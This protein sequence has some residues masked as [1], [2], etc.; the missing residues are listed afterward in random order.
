MELDAV[1]EKSQNRCVAFICWKKTCHG[2]SF[3]HLHWESKS[4]NCKNKADPKDMD[5]NARKQVAQET[6]NGL[7]VTFSGFSKCAIGRG[8]RNTKKNILSP[9]RLRMH[10]KIGNRNLWHYRTTSIN[11]QRI[12]QKIFPK[13][14]NDVPTCLPKVKRLSYH[15]SWMIYF[16]ICPLKW[17]TSVVM[18]RYL[19]ILFRFQLNFIILQSTTLVIAQNIWSK[20]CAI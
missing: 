15:G 5:S 7:S 11:W 19:W 4:N 18:N 12:R 17:K 16:Y 9:P 8:L 6:N 13:P 10:G 3:L 2:Y 14:F 1:K 20:S